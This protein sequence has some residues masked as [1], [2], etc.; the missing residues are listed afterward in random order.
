MSNALA[1]WKGASGLRS[2]LSATRHVLAGRPP[3]AIRANG[4][5]QLAVLASSRCRIRD[6]SFVFCME[7]RLEEASQ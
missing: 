6:R 2:A 5:I 1:S 7:V 4:G 3:R